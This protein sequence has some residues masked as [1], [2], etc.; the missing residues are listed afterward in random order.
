MSSPQTGPAKKTVYVDVDEEITG[1]IDKVLTSKESIV[2]LVLPKRATVLQSIVNMKL[3]KRAATQNDKKVVLITSESTLMPLA[4][5]AGL[6]V[7]AN[8]QSRPY[9]PAAPLA[10]AP[11]KPDPSPESGDDLIDPST[12]IGSLIDPQETASEPIEIDN[13]P[14]ETAASAAAATKAVKPDKTKK[15]PNFKKFRVL[16]FAGAAALILLLGGGYWALAVAP[17]ATVTLRTES[18]EH[19]TQAQFTAD[20]E[21][22]QLDLQE[23]VVPAKLGVLKKPESEK[24]PATGE[25]D[26]GTK[27][28]GNVT[29]RN[30]TDDPATIPAGTGISNG[31]F[32]FITQA[33][34][35]LDKGEFSSKNSG[36]QCQ[37]SGDHVG[38]VGVVAQNNGD[39]FNLSPRTYAVAGYSGVIAQGDQMSGGT[40]KVIKV[41]SQGDVDSAKKKITDK[42]SA[43]VEEL[44]GQ[45][46]KDDSIAI[47]DT[48]SAGTPAFTTTP[49]VGA[50]AT[51]VTVAGEINYTM[52]GIKVSDLKKIVEEQAKDKIDT[53]KQSILS[54]GFDDASFEVGAKKKSTTDIKLKTTLLT[55]PE[56]N[57][58]QLK[59]EFA[60]KKRGD[61]EGQ[62]KGR[63]GITEARVD[64][65]PFWVS[66]I[67]NNPSKV[68][69][70]IEQA[71]GTQIKP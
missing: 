62:L 59:K 42:Q 23:A 54:Y 33:N 18:S 22:D 65:K 14:K 9:V 46:K 7:A 40:S 16:L 21:A 3:L 51:E 25:K 39:Q 45:L 52:L 44:K 36:S 60:G 71:D 50:E 1:I 47:I 31:S 41:V 10:S 11:P 20:T 55:G 57:Q 12:P 17:K 8:L 49:A 15:I 56:I 37:S 61:V 67:P 48:F 26:N 63:P 6:H 64:F 24:V 5:A 4:G 2:A 28:S 43:A 53:S 27:A 29:L 38:N 32:T 30:C 19:L 13:R 69:F 58:D 70:I 68:T 34:I 66:K 35:K